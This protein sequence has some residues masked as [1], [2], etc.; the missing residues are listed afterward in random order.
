MGSARRGSN[1]LAVGEC[2][3]PSCIMSEACTSR[4]V[5][6]NGLKSHSCHLL[7]RVF[8]KSRT[9]TDKLYVYVCAFAIL[10]SGV[11][12]WLAC[13]AHNPKVHGSRPCSAIARNSCFAPPQQTGTRRKKR[14]DDPAPLQGQQ[15]FLCASPPAGAALRVGHPLSLLD[16]S[17]ASLSFPSLSFASLSF[18]SL[19]FASLSFAS[20][21]PVFLG[22]GE[23]LSRPQNA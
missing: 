8:L 17:F 23:F 7:N 13:W 20:L 12:Q 6:P 22:L 4:A 11:A 2:V 9:P 10:H 19:S 1:P 3:S 16:L 21:S 5:D 15:W 18:A 14:N